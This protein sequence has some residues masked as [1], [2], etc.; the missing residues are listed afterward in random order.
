MTAGRLWAEAQGLLRSG[1]R[2]AAYGK[3]LQAVELAREGG[4][5]AQGGEIL[6]R[7]VEAFG[8]RAAIQLA[9]GEYWLKRVSRASGRV[10]VDD[11]TSGTRKCTGEEEN[12]K[13]VTALLLH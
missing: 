2:E 3:A 1:D 13:E 4:D 8:D 7:A 9:M 5:P 12:T 10:G 6:R 11:S